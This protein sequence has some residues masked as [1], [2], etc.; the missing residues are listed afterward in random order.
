MKKYD[1]LEI[2]ETDETPDSWL[3]C[4]HCERAYRLRE[5]R[6][7]RGLELCKYEDCSGDPV[8]DARNYAELREHVHPEWPEVPQHG[9]VYA[10]YT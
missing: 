8:M 5:R 2:L 9:V 4:G 10:L 6:L 1:R 7:M 3:W